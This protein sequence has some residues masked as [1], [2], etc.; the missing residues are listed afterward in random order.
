MNMATENVSVNLN[1]EF[2]NGETRFLVT[3]VNGDDLRLQEAND[4]GS[5]IFASSVSLL[6]AQG[7]SL[8]KNF[9]LEAPGDGYAEAAESARHELLRKEMEDA[10]VVETE[11]IRKRYGS[12][13]LRAEKIAAP[14]AVRRKEALAFIEHLRSAVRGPLCDNF[15]P[16]EVADAAILAA[17]SS[18]IA[19]A[20]R[21]RAAPLAPGGKPG[22]T[23]TSNKETLIEQD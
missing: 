13:I 5:P 23:I 22:Q 9:A 15:A 17:I 21:D 20:G 16:A 11:K 3:A 4:V 8:Q 1:D 18:A 10:I 12:R 2:V 19:A 7:Y 14:V 6:M